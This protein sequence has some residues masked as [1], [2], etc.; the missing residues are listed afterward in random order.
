MFLL[1]L[2]SDI[3]FS[4]LLWLFP[5]LLAAQEPVKGRVEYSDGQAREGALQLSQGKKLRI[6]VQK[7][8]TDLD[9]EQI[10]EIRF[11]PESEELA[12]AYRFPEAGKSVK[13]T[14]GK[15]K[16]VRSLLARIQLINGEELSGHLYTTVLY[17]ESGDQTEKVVLL[18][19]QTG[20][21]GQ[22]LEEL[23]YPTLI[24]LEN[25]ADAAR[26][27]SRVTLPA[28]MIVPGTKV[29]A[30]LRPSL[31]R[32]PA[33]PL[34]PANVFSL[35]APAGAQ[36]LVAVSQGDTIT[37]GWPKYANP[38]LEELT[39]KTIGLAADF[40]DDRRL[41]GLFTENND[42]DVYSVVML[43]RKAKTTHAGAVGP[44]WTLDIW[45][46]K[47]DAGAGKLTLS[48]R[49]YCFTGRITEKHPEPRIVLSEELWN[50]VSVRKN[51]K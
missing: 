43:K 1:H 12:Q 47:Y 18:A 19:K 26:V 21:E 20:E 44:P 4:L 33:K 6:F 40:Y 39:R 2:K 10:R 22:S 15:P 35:A 31:S 46:W 32:L 3:C 14:W 7:A 24:T 50:A 42:E 25:K 17:L 36:L 38:S 11:Y 23:V 48:T 27:E 9:L 51:E 49:G 8:F 30:L 16:P 45:H 28:A 34:Q 29:A 5:F 41:V 37:V 13:E